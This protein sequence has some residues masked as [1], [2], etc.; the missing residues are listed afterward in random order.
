MAQ[1]LK[2][3]PVAAAITENLIRRAQALRSEGVLPKLA[4]LRVGARVVEASRA[5]F[6]ES[7]LA[8]AA[9]RDDVDR[10]IREHAR[11]RLR[12]VGNFARKLALRV[13][14][15]ALAV[16]VDVSLLRFQVTER[17]G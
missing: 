16:Y 4:M 10:P 8:R 6:E 9:H 14:G 15:K 13:L 3:A 1:L 11:V 12:H 2:G 7:L 17:F 5:R